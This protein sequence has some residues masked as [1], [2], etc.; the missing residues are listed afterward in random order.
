MSGSPSPSEAAQVFSLIPVYGVGGV[1]EVASEEKIGGKGVEGMCSKDMID[2]KMTYEARKMSSATRVITCEA[3]TEK[4][5]LMR[6][7]GEVLSVQ[8]GTNQP[9]RLPFRPSNRF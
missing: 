4:S 9:P 5:L 1:S 7:C 3:R 2:D 8:C 6:A